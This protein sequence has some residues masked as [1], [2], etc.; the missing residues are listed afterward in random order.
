MP[1]LDLPQLHLPEAGVYLTAV[2][3]FPREPD[4]HAQLIQAVQN[5][6]LRRVFTKNQNKEVGDN[7]IPL[8]RQ[9][10]IGPTLKDT[11]LSNPI[12]LISPSYN[13]IRPDVAYQLF[14]YVL[15]CL[16]ADDPAEPATLE[17][18]RKMIGSA[19]G[20][21]GSLPG[22]GRSQVIDIWR[23]FSPVVHLLTAKAIL[24]TLWND[25]SGRGAGGRLA[26]ILAYAEALRL[27]GEAH[28]P[29]R[30]KTSLLDRN[31]TWKVPDWVALPQLPDGLAFP[32][33][34]MLR[35]EMA[36]WPKWPRP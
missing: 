30:S 27:R 36:K 2:M 1:V 6:A 16:D 26:G 23:D 17:H 35:A 29:P 31:E 7:A 28:K 11:V 15:A 8:L 10:V 3:F 14:I 9:A 20:K 24:H 25:S 34:A 4:R 12:N 18:A 19:G 13:I 5:E 22:L 21:Y 33:P 32:T